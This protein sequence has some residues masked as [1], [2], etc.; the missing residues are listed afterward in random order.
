MKKIRLLCITC[1]RTDLSYHKQVELACQGGTDMIQ[2]RDKNLSDREFLNLSVELEAICKRYN[3]YFT[4]NNRIDIAN[5]S[6]IDGVHIGQ[7]DL[8]VDYARKILGPTKIIGLSASNYEQV[9]Q[10]SKQ[11][12]DYIGYGA[13]FAT[14]TKPE[15][16]ASGLAALSEIK[17]Q[18]NIPLIAIG[19][20]DETNV[21]DVICAG[22]DGVAVVRAV[23]GAQDVKKAA[24][25][26]KKII[27]QAEQEKR[28]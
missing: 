1:P 19:G 20:I 2:L 8:P 15:S 27:L 17:K 11:D 12:I 21:A 16:Q 26:I 6:G 14:E 9:A 3:V 24:E 10:A 22:A 5:A 25:N 4:V 23:C 28:N 7:S 13:I 18:V